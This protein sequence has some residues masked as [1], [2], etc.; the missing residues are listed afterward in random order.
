[1]QMPAMFT[2]PKSPL[3]DPNRDPA[4]QP[5]VIINL[6]YGGEDNTDITGREQVSANLSIMYREMMSN[7]KN[8]RLFLGSPYRAGDDPDPGSGSIERVPHGPVHAWSGDR[9]QSNL[10]D[11]GNFYSAGWDPISYSHHA[12]VDRLW[13]IWKTLGGNRR[14]HS[15]PDWLNTQFIFY[16]E[17]A[18]LVRVKVRD[19]LETKSLGYVY[20]KV[21]I[22][23][24][25]SRSTP[26]RS[27]LKSL[28]SLTKSARA[29]EPSGQIVRFPKALTSVLRTE[30]NRPRKSR[31]K[32]EKEDEEEVLVIGV[33][34]ERDV[35]VKF[36][37][38]INEE[39]D[40]SL[41]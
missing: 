17:N 18:N 27:K 36:D 25:G 34:L 31:S 41:F 38:F 29:A 21:D 35:F 14:D 37:V 33:E 4:H 23:W 16:D 9:R 15:D 3:Y 30:V 32:K 11:M 8:A 20:Q 26:R 22:P 10:E 2:E 19:C 5:P 24:A 40:G 12:N 7:A 28:F 1:M 6:D 13:S 39:D